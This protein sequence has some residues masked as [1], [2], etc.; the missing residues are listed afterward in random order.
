MTGAAQEP[1]A[2]DPEAVVERICE[3]TAAIREREVERAVRRMEDAGGLTEPQCETVRA[4]GRSLT[5]ALVAPA[6]DDVQEA[7]TE[8]LATAIE[9][10][11]K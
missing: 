8:T 2:T 4:M 6:V 1:P 5:D 9:L 3:R 11:E 7:E 10:F